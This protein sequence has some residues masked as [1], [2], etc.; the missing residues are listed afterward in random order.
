MDDLDVLLC[1]VRISWNDVT[2][3]KHWRN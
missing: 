2:C 1:D 3:L